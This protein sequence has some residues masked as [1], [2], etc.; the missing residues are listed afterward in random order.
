MAVTAAVDTDRSDSAFVATATVR[1]PRSGLSVTTV[2]VPAAPVPAGGAA[3]FVMQ[4]ANGGP[5]AA[6]GVR[7][8]DTVSGNLT[9]RAATCRASGGAECPSDLSPSMTLASLPAG[10]TLS[11][12]VNTVA[13]SDANGAITNTMTVS[14][15]NDADT[16][17]N[18]ATATGTA[19]ATALS[20]SV[21]A[22]G[23]V[24]G[25][26][27][28]A[29]TAVV[30]NA[31]PSTA[32]S[33]PLTL[34]LGSGLSRGGS[35][36]CTPSGG[37]TCPSTTGLSMTAPSVPAGG[38]LSLRVPVVADA[39]F[40]GKAALTLTAD[41][42]GDTR[43]GNDSASASVAITSTDL[44]VSMSVAESEVGAGGSVV[45]TATLGNPGSSAAS[46]IT[47]THAL[48]GAGA[49]GATA[50][51]TCR[52][53]GGAT[54]PST[55][56]TMTVPSLG[57]GRSLT[58]TISVPVD[59]SARGTVTSRFTVQS[60]GDPGSSNNSASAS[61][62]VVD[63]RNGSYA[64]YTGTGG[65][66]TMVL[67]FD[68]RSYTMNGG[69]AV[70]FTGS[71]DEFTVAGARR[72][73]VAGDLIIGLHDFGAGSQPYVAARSFGEST[74]AVQGAYNIALRTGSGTGSG[75]ASAVIGSDGLLFLCQQATRIPV[76]V[77]SCPVASLQVYTLAVSSGVF[78]ATP[79]GAG[80]SFT[81]RVALSEGARILLAAEGGTLRVGPMDPPAID[82][83]SLRGPDSRGQWQA[84]T[85]S[86]AAYSSTDL[87]STADSAA[88]GAV[89]GFGSSSMRQGSR[90][91]DGARLYV[92]QGGPLAVVVGHPN[93]AAN[94]L[95]QLLVP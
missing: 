18:A 57:A 69:A 44:G 60:A 67:D 59:G 2:S 30:A 53:S 56:S 42:E 76:A 29:F 33:V 65:T 61:A 58:F 70:A 81:F 48:S 1:T 13:A 8:V 95:L 68:A 51:I 54:C 77:T 32:T 85:L 21:T 28:A 19:F 14:A 20:A 52:A 88:L 41:A 7:I 10:G 80:S 15:S 64:V 83:G 34:E 31:G 82:G 47:L 40:N 62:T 43:S 91:S 55:G 12:T 35:V 94:G 73:R 71:G 63:A 3:A 4:V 17:D 45:F 49:A 22:P 72:L 38:S 86:S 37:A 92:M 9:Y 27:L 93:D 24:V 78:T 16:S 87:A 11:F 74:S 84:V 90:A 46:D 23:A 25:G 6:T 26:G 75:A 66:A 5:D 36:T 39:G 89:A 50:T 79:Q